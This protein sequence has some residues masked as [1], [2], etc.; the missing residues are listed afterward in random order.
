MVVTDLFSKRKKKQASE[1]K[2]DVY[3]YEA[4]PEPFRLLVTLQS[5][6]RAIVPFV[7]FRAGDVGVL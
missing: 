1:G 4:L 7:P 6:L 3:Q 2:P 5:P